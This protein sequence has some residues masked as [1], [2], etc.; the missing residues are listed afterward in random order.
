MVPRLCKQ[1]NRYLGGLQFH[2]ER[3][4]GH[5]HWLLLLQRY[6]RRGRQQLGL[7][8]RGQKYKG[9]SRHTRESHSTFTWRNIYISHCNPKHTAV[10]YRHSNTRRE[11]RIPNTV[12]THTNYF[13]IHCTAY[14]ADKECTSEWRSCRRSPSKSSLDKSMSFCINKYIYTHI[15]D[16]THLAQ[17]K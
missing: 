13:K 4:L 10:N 8:R 6:D 5:S 9:I 7:L 11:V 15:R 2:R 17:P 3:I 12:H 1:R 16:Y 14:Q